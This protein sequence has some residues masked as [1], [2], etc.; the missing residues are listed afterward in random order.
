MS[1]TSMAEELVH[2]ASQMTLCCATAQE[3]IPNCG[4]RRQAFGPA[5][6]HARQSVE[7]P[8][9]PIIMMVVVF[10][11]LEVLVMNG[12][13]GR[14][15]VLHDVWRGAM[16]KVINGCVMN[17]CDDVIRLSGLRRLPRRGGSGC[18][19]EGCTLEGISTGCM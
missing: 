5:G 8:W 9:R 16:Y 1:L 6:G 15:S 4:A 7:P 12:S 13:G 11:Y 14:R 17:G 19:L 3:R 18:T 2:K 10:M